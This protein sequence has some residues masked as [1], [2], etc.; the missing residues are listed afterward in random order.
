MGATDL[1]H[2]VTRVET[3][4]VDQARTGQQFLKAAVE[5]AAGPG[6]AV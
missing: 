5:G 6:G 3:C 1:Y 4:L 2:P